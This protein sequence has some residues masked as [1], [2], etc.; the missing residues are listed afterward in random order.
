VI[1]AGAAPGS[2]ASGNPVALVAPRLDAADTPAARGLIEAWLTARRLYGSLGEACVQAVDA[3]RLPASANEGARFAKLMADPPLEAALVRA[4]REGDPAAGLATPAF[5]VN[6]AAALD[7]LLKGCGVRTGARVARVEERPGGAACVLDS[8]ETLEA[9]VVVVCAGDRLP[10]VSGIAAPAIE[11][12]LGQIEFTAA[13]GL[14]PFAAADGGYA[15]AAF[16]RLV[17]GA[18]FE[19]APD[20]E[21]PVTDAA[22]AHNLQILERLRPDLA[23]GLAGEALASRA[24]VRATTRDRL[25]F[26]GAPPGETPAEAVRLIGGL[27]SRGWL[28]APLLAEIVASEVHGE[29]AP[30]EAQV[31]DALSPD[32]FRLREVRKSG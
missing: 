28:W 2:G 11:G 30:C 3:W 18:T 13:E 5:A 16:G 25:P 27:G 10:W 9:D 7:A 19:A 31:L 20:G 29:P 15:L 1:D 22:R 21:P 32:R 23:A 12:R 24:A 26:A 8:G 6:T 4:L 14:E 17:F